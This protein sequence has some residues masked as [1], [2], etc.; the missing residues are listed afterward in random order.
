M[1][2]GLVRTQNYQKKTTKKTTKFLP[3]DTHTFVWVIFCLSSKSLVLA[4]QNYQ[5]VT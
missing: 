3:P 2:A 1:P 5:V 4:D